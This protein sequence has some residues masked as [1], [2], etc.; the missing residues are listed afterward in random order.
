M[1]LRELGA[2]LVALCLAACSSS[3]A[4]S[5]APYY[6]PKGLNWGG[7]TGSLTPKCGPTLDEAIPEG[8]DGVV[9]D[10]R[11]CSRVP[12]ETDVQLTGSSGEAI[13]TEWVPLGNGRFLIR[14]TQA[15]S[16][17]SGQYRVSIAGSS[18]TFEVGAS[19]P[20]PTTLG[21]IEQREALQCDVDLALVLD[22][23]VLPYASL[24]RVGIT[25]D[26]VEAL[27]TE[28]GQ[29]GSDDGT[30]SVRCTNCL[31]GPRASVQAFGEI[32]GE[33]NVLE[34]PPLQ[35]QTRCSGAGSEDAGDGAGCGFARGGSSQGV[36]GGM[37]LGLL[38]L[39]RRA[40]AKKSGGS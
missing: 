8:V 33:T 30:L 26:G 11:A 3:D 32:A 36:W 1:R 14:P 6:F 21:T 40:R 38:A 31:Q 18:Q 12:T 17:A 35:I 2:A 15:A 7:Q 5:D 27:N 10:T 37:A 20:K 28:Y 39:L 19:S 9:I 34:T 22:A 16:L 25:L 24:L 23:A 29:L 13:E 4:S